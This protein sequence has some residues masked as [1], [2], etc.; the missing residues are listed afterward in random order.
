MLAVAEK[1]KA[2]KAAPPFVIELEED[3]PPP[4]EVDAE[5]EADTK[6]DADPKKDTK[7]NGDPKKDTKKDGDPKKDDPGQDDETTEPFKA[8]QGERG[9][10]REVEGVQ[11]YV[12]GKERTEAGVIVM[13]DLWGWHDGRIRA[14][15]EYLASAL[16]ALVV[17]PKLLADPPFE[18]GTDGDG[19]PADF[20]AESRREEMRVWLMGY[21]WETIESKIKIVSNFLRNQGKVKRI[22]GAAFGFGAWVACYTSVVIGEMVGMAMAYPL[23]HYLEEIMGGDPYV[24]AQRVKCPTLFMTTSDDD[25]TYAP[26]GEIHDLV[27]LRHPDSDLETFPTMKRGWIIRGDAADPEIKSSAE[28]AVTILQR[29]LRK[30]IWPAP[31]G[32]DAAAL[33][34]ACTEQDSDLI[35][36]LLELDLPTN[37]RDAVDAVGLGPIHYAAKAGGM[38][39]IRLL[40]E[41]QADIHVKGGP[42]K[43]T[44]LHI[45]V[46]EGKGKAAV[47]LL[48]FQADIECRDAG[49]QTPLHHACLKGHMA[50]ANV[51]LKKK[52]DMHAVDTAKQTP[53]HL[54]SWKGKSE[55][56]KVL[57]KLKAEIDIEDLRGQT[58]LQRA[59]QG[60]S[61]I[62]KDMLEIEAE[63]REAAAFY[64]ETGEL[65]PFVQLEKRVFIPM[66]EI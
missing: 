32:K 13:A 23:A 37:G 18:D 4:P 3:I 27:T 41:A 15:A 2:P 46:R 20:D 53:L 63:H 25:K 58:P 62:V 28:Q 51:L 42:C 65:N 14:V 48:H 33:R 55:I 47:S 6:K 45:A 54:A 10:T 50:V 16:D 31:L 61:E 34:F 26:G 9:I 17:V 44:P 59:I 36:E 57:L 52:A 11:M 39:P 49:L 1:Q 64:G 5:K 66:A 60:G 24:M 19:L 40:V 29:F 21:L 7:K 56:V 12:V 35:A 43:E 30:F 8:K 22:G 38:Q